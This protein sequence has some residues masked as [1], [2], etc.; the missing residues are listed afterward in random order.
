MTKDELVNQIKDKAFLVHENTPRTTRYG[1]ESI[2]VNYLVNNNGSLLERKVEI[3]I[4]DGQAY[5]LDQKPSIL[6][7]VVE[8]EKAEQLMTDRDIISFVESLSES[9]NVISLS[10]N[11]RQSDNI[12]SVDIEDGIRV[13]TKRYR[14]IPSPSNNWVQPT[15]AHDAYSIDSVVSHKSKTWQSL[16]D[17]NVWE[18]SESNPTLWKEIEGAIIREVQN[19]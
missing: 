6:R 11:L 18:P 4:V 10:V 8:P 3:Y 9:Y 7:D 1:N 19:D 15:G 13:F 17:D 16:V 12:V 5:W 2:T 14:I